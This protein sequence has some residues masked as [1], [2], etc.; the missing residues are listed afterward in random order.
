MDFLLLY[1]NNHYWKLDYLLD[2]LSD[3]LVVTRGFKIQHT[4]VVNWGHLD[5]F[6]LLEISNRAEELGRETAVFVSFREDDF[7]GREMERNLMHQ[8]FHNVDFDHHFA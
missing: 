1:V 2:L 5:I 6:L 7:V 8:S 4:N 3:S